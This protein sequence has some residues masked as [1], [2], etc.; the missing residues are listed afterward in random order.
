VFLLLCSA[1]VAACGGDASPDKA[2]TA[3]AT[4]THT[5]KVP[6]ET[7]AATKQGDLPDL[8]GED[9]QTAQDT[10]Q[11]HGFYDLASSDA[12]GEGRNQVLDRN[13]VVCSQNPGPGQHRTDAAIA[14]SV[15]KI[16][17]SCP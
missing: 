16:G 11:A 14:F 1:G 17:E 15:V 12:T 6:A 7:E 9:L 10:A 3:T 5:T 13:W 2:P 8:T 4:V